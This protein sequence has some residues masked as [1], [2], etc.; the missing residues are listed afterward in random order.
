M[1]ISHLY[2]DLEKVIFMYYVPLV[3][4]NF[5]ATVSNMISGNEEV[6]TCDSRSYEVKMGNLELQRYT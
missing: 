6:H 2:E 4:F 1:N 5:L 3:H